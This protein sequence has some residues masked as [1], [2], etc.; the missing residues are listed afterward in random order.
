MIKVLIETHKIYKEL[1]KKIFKNQL[2]NEV[3]ITFNNKEK[4]T[5]KEYWMLDNKGMFQLDIPI[6][7]FMEGEETF[8]TE[9]LLMMIHLVCKQEGIKD[10][11]KGCNT[12]DYIIKCQEYGLEGKIPSEELE[13]I[14]EE[15]T[16]D[17]SIFDLKPIKAPSNR[18]FPQ[19]KPK[20]KYFCTGCE[21]EIS[22]EIEDLKVRCKDCDLDFVAENF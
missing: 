13:K 21:K 14:F 19:R 7:T 5:S 8:V 9:I 10:V 17:K 1:N 6:K 2:P 20:F 4:C 3:I 18:E 15:L 12:E 22:S 16:Y 11:V